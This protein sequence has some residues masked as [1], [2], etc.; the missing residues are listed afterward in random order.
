VNKRAGV[1][2]LAG[3][4][5]AIVLLL[6]ASFVLFTWIVPTVGPEGTWF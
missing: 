4:A 5:L 1:Q 6:G 3:L 2:F